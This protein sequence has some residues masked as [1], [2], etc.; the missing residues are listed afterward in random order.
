MRTPE[1]GGRLHRHHRYEL[2]HV[3]LDHVP[4]RAFMIVE[5]PTPPFH[6][7]CFCH[8]DLHVLDMFPVEERLENGVAEPEG[9]NVLNGFLSQVVVN[10]IDLVGAEKTFK[11]L[12]QFYSARQ[13]MPKGF[14]DD[15]AGPGPVNLGVGQLVN[16]ELFDDQREVFGVGC[17]IKEA[18]AREIEFFLQNLQVLGQALMSR[19]SGKIGGMVIQ[20]LA[21]GVRK[22]GRH[23][24]LAKCREILLGFLTKLL[25]VFGRLPT[26]TT[27]KW[28]G[29]Y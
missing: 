26:P 20:V 27:A 24:L 18:I 4:H 8:G 21:E 1:R 5:G 19:C 10:A 16:R 23:L 14:L 29:R 15:D 13:I 25:V 12:V 7:D 2:E 28:G 17:Q 22:V 6:A 11:G 3:V 9:Q